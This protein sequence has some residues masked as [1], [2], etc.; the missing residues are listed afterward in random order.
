MNEYTTVMG[1]DLGDRYSYFR[2]VAR[3]DGATV[4]EGRVP[5]TRKA[6]QKRLKG[7]PPTLIAMEVGTHSPWV[8]RLCEAL[9]HTT[10]VGNPAKLAAIY[11]NV[12]KCDRVD[13]HTLAK[14]A[15]LDPDL[16]HPIRHR[17]ARAQRDLAVMRSRAALIKAR[18]LLINHVRGSAKAQGDRVPLGSAPSFHKTARRALPDALAQALQPVLDTIAHLSDQLKA[19]DKTLEAMAEHDYPETE[20]LRQVPGVGLITALAFVLHIE[21]PARFAR[22]RHVGAYVGL[23]PRRDQS[24]AIDRQ[25]P[26]TKAG[27]RHLR[28]LLVTCA[29]YIL[30]PFGP[31]TAL[32]RFGLAMAA[33]GGKAAK[34][35]AV[36][37]VARKLA[38]LL[39]RLWV[40]GEVYEPL[41]N[42]R[43]A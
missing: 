37:A 19:L 40:T 4:A 43:K 38:V 7:L 8:S 22:S 36:V 27:S 10:L 3:A 16:L 25:L 6:L 17:G 9:G 2:I 28:R 32:R 18:T 42:A 5:T 41:R 26:I 14:L 34:K 13:A 35:R 1:L 21:D 33:R 39:H 31:D 30:G 20:L 15:R 29:H 11:T 24:G 23:T 12:R